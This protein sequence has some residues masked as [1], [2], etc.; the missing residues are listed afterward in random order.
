MNN[1][2]QQVINTQNTSVTAVQLANIPVKQV[3]KSHCPKP[4]DLLTINASLYM[5]NETL[6]PDVSV[7]D[8]SV[9]H[10]TMHESVV[11]GERVIKL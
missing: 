2:C 11:W 1:S 7:E 8:L 4:K 6:S 10:Y 3:S 5:L 9:L